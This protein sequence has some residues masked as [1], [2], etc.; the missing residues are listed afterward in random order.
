M[1][2]VIKFLLINIYSHYCETFFKYII[3]PNYCMYYIE[4]QSNHIY[5]IID[6]GYLYTYY[7]P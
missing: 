7:K 3:K 5:G 6:R 4:D 2:K 1:L